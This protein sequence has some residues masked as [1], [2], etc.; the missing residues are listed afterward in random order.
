M[1]YLEAWGSLSGASQWLLRTIW[2]GYA[3][4]FARRPPRFRSILET[5]VRDESAAVLRAEVVSLLRKDAI[6]SVP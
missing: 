5:F 2:L 3:I 4:Q 1:R 6:E